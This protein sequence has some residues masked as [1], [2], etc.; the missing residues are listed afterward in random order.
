[1]PCLQGVLTGLFPGTQQP[2]ITVHTSTGEIDEVLYTNVRSCQ[3]LHTLMQDLHR[4]LKGEPGCAAK[5]QWQCCAA[6]LGW[7]QWCNGCRVLQYRVAQL[8]CSSA[9]QP[10]SCRASLWPACLSRTEA[11]RRGDD[12][13][14]EPLQE[15][16]RAA[17]GLPADHQVHWVDLHDAMTTMLTHGKEVPPGGLCMVMIGPGF[18]RGLGRLRQ[19]CRGAHCMLSLVAAASGRAAG[20]WMVCISACRCLWEACRGVDCMHQWGCCC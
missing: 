6:V 7:L 14:T 16:V 18:G 19:A 20:V 15:R 2:P 1:M 10:T 11:S 12:A 17:L 5:L 13:H 3:R 4:E 8:S 9:A